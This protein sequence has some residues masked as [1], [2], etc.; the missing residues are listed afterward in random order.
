M[1]E[2]RA[3][4][5]AAAR[6]SERAVGARSQAAMAQLAS[7]GGDENGDDQVTRSESGDGRASAEEAAAPAAV[8]DPTAQPAKGVLKRVP[9]ASASRNVRWGQ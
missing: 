2:V 6:G 5:C 3:R 9:S 7:G 1:L 8:H 4:T